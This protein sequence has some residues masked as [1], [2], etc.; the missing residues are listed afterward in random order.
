MATWQLY[1]T[2]RK[3]QVQ[4]NG[5]IDLAAV[6]L[7]IAWVTSAYVPDQNAHDFWSD[8]SANEVS[9]NNYTA[10]GN[11]VANVTITMNASG[12]VTVDGDDPATWLQDAAGFSNGRFTIL[13]R[14]TGVA[15]TSELIAYA[16]HTTDQGNTTADL[17]VQLDA[18]GIFTSPR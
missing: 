9:G 7:K 1:D 18:A 11:T 6:T 13:Y 4:G 8:A 2:F 12:L 5:Q 17:T 15:T 14:D 10:G 16:D 3:K